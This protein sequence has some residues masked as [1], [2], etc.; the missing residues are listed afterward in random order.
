MLFEIE[1]GMRPEKKVEVGVKS[2]LGCVVSRKRVIKYKFYCSNVVFKD[3]WCN[4]HIKCYFS[5]TC[6]YLKLFYYK[7]SVGVGIRRGSLW[8]LKYSSLK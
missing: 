5:L 3:Y 1:I 8:S 2:L 4:L 7:V 6:I